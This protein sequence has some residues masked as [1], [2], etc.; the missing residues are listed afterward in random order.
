MK[1]LRQA[2]AAFVFRV[3][4]S[5]RVKELFLCL[6]C[7]PITRCCSSSRW[8]LNGIAGEA[9]SDKVGSRDLKCNVDLRLMWQSCSF[10]L[11]VPPMLYLWVGNKHT[12]EDINRIYTFLLH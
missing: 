6:L 5:V 2:L 9:Y 1:T 3:R 11:T 12:I 7:Q 4:G 10:S 8:K